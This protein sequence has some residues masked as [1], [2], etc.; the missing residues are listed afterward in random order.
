[1]TRS[2]G[3]QVLLIV[4]LLLVI[5]SSIPLGGPSE[6]DSNAL[7][8]P[9]PALP[10]ACAKVVEQAS[11]GFQGDPCDSL[12][13]CTLALHGAAYIHVPLAAGKAIENAMLEPLIQ[14]GTQSCHDSALVASSKSPSWL[15]A[16]SF[17]IVS[18]P[19]SRLVSLYEYA[20]RGGEGGEKDERKFA[21]VSNTTDFTDFVNQLYLA[22]REPGGKFQFARLSDGFFAPARDFVSSHE[23]LLVGRLL[24]TTRLEDELAVL[25]EVL[26]LP[27]MTSPKRP[28]I[29][30][31]NPWP[32][33]YVRNPQTLAQ[34]VAM[35]DA[36]FSL[37]GSNAEDP[38]MEP[39]LPT[40][41]ALFRTRSTL[42][43]ETFPSS[44]GSGCAT[45]CT[46]GTLSTH[47]YGFDVVPANPRFLLE[48]HRLVEKYGGDIAMDKHVSLL[49]VCCQKKEAH[50]AIQPALLHSMNTFLG[51]GREGGTTGCVAADGQQKRRRPER[52]VGVSHYVSVADGP[53][54][55]H[56]SIVLMLEKT[57]NH[58]LHRTAAQAE[59]AMEL[60]GIRLKARRK[61]QQDFHMTLA[62]VNGSTFPVDIV[63][64]E[65]NL[66]LK[67]EEG[68]GNPQLLLS[69][70]Y[71]VDSTS[72][73]EA[74]RRRPWQP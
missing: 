12:V 27:A 45:K 14:I 15:R 69:D 72:R 20:R 10:A 16:R 44:G 57:I 40:P 51:E 11:R 43:S 36:D 35:Y 19:L 59:E 26:P 74:V 49:Y 33:Y 37:S 9:Q 50:S 71:A 54:L 7:R 38:L 42:M 8:Q 32:S 6:G 28:S 4:E 66:R 23:R 64:D 62:S 52:S 65:L 67:V 1:M 47:S 29:T 22:T 41:E 25:H 39:S 53:S 70:C 17:A 46:A 31:H 5:A 63:I 73:P 2:Y 58:K 55:D 30:P 3:R 60:S 61:D 48:T 24:H 13:E 18:H 56:V 21:W 68:I 34:S